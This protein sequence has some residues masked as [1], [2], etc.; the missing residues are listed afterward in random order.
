MPK[1]LRNLGN[2]SSLYV[3]PRADRFSLLL[4]MAQSQNVGIALGHKKHPEGFSSVD[5]GPLLMLTRRA[6][7][8]R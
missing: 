6:L 7:P 8:Q 1:E 5:R 3:D 2:L 4:D